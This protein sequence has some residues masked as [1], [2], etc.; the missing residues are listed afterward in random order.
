MAK[1]RGR[2]DG[3][4]RGK[5]TFRRLGAEFDDASY[6]RWDHRSLLSDFYNS[7]QKDIHRYLIMVGVP[8]HSSS[9]R[10][11]WYEYPHVVP[12]SSTEIYHMA[13]ST[14]KTT[15]IVGPKSI[16]TPQKGIKVRLQVEI[17]SNSD[18]SDIVDKFIN[19]F[20]YLRE[21]QGDE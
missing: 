19:R 21:E 2:V 20:P 12:R 4:L 6:A 13:G 10:T 16:I 5:Y 11:S 1:Y 18:T 7:P 9:Y 3:K 14:I 8:I 17:H 15:M